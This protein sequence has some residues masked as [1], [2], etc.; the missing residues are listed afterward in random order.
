M[1]N[2]IYPSKFKIFNYS[3]LGFLVGFPGA[4]MLWNLLV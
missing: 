3:A 2:A 1:E 4:V